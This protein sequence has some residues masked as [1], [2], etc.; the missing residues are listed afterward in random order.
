MPYTCFSYYFLSHCDSSGVIATPEV[1]DW[2][3]LGINDTYLVAASDGVF[4]VLTSQNVCDI[5][6]ENSRSESSSSC[7]NSLADCIV[8]A[9]FKKGSW[10]NLSTIVVPLQSTLSHNIQEESYTATAHTNS[11]AVGLQDRYEL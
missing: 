2:Q 8:K 9:A 1:T 3:L 11:T 6:S 4:E 10:D 7:L 5:L